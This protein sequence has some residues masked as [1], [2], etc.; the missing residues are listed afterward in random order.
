MVPPRDLN[1]LA[2]FV[3]F[4]PRAAV[5]YLRPIALSQVAQEVRF[6]GRA[7]EELCVDARIPEAG[8]RSGVDTERPR[9]DDEVGALER[10][11]AQRSN[12]HVLLLFLTD[13][14]VLHRR[15]VGK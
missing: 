14:I 15:V 4:E 5:K 6:D 2:R 1:D 11:I 8:H 3:E 10:A 9:G 7:R 13:K 12:L